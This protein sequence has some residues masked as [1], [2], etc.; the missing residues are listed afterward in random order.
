M[1]VGSEGVQSGD[2][3]LAHTRDRVAGSREPNKGTSPWKSPV[4]DG[5]FGQLS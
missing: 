2:T 3:S 4:E 5:G 1:P